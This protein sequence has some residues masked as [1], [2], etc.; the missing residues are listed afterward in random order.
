MNTNG[1]HILLVYD[2]SLTAVELPSKWGSFMQ[3]DGG[4]LNIIC[5]YILISI[6]M[7]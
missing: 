2:K 4:K 3:Y 7:S 1:T 6:L 5:K